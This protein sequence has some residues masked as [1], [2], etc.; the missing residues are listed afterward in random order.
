MAA[1]FFGRTEHT[2]DAKGRVVL[3]SRYRP[4]F[5]AGGYLSQYHDRCLALW[6]PEEFEHQM[7]AMLEAASGGRE[8]RNV[9]RVW[10]S[11]AEQVEVDRQGRLAIPAYLRAFAWLDGDVLINGAIDRIELWN[12]ALWSE[13]VEPS[14]SSLARDTSPEPLAPGPSARARGR[15]ASPGAEDREERP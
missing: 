15:P 5:E 3:P 14:E 8:E 1:R 7:S 12:P 11:R 10:A 2:L 6:A 4:A 9:A 13:L